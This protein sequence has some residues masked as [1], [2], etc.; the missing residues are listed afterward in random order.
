MSLV[1]EHIPQ[2][3]SWEIGPQPHEYGGFLGKYSSSTV[4]KWRLTENFTHSVY[5]LVIWQCSLN[6]P[7]SRKIL[8]KISYNKRRCE[9]YP[10]CGLF[11]SNI[12]RR[13]R[14]IVSQCRI[15][16]DCADD[17]V[18]SDSTLVAHSRGWFSFTFSECVG[19]QN[20]IWAVPRN[21]QQCEVGVKYRPGST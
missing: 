10:K 19:S 18:G 12:W 11:V 14:L 9:S 15:R 21:N 2:F 8:S 16:S 3:A 7:W 4:G 5:I 1:H 17:S 6:K 13:P 20:C